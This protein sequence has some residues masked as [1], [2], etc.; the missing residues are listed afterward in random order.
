MSEEIKNLLEK[1]CIVEVTSKPTVINP[2]TVAKNESTKKLR[3]V[4]DL[5]HVN[6]HLHKFTTKFEGLET[7]KS[8]F[9]QG[10]IPSNFRHEI[11]LSSPR[12]PTRT[13]TVFGI[14][15]ATQ[16]LRV[17]NITLRVSVCRE[18]CYNSRFQ[19]SDLRYKE[20]NNCAGISQLNIQD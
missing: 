7:L 11:R 6:P 4:L 20:R 8:F 13:P 1:H 3:L 12:N 17:H 5:R 18:Y 10:R 9:S 16:T 19:Y 14:F 2:L 15:L